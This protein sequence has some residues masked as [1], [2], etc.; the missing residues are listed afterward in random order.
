MKQKKRNRYTVQ[1]SVERFT[2]RWQRFDYSLTSQ[3]V[4]R[5]HCNN[6]LNRYTVHQI[7]ITLHRMLA[8]L[9]PLSDKSTY[10]K[11]SLNDIQSVNN[12]LTPIDQFSDKFDIF[13]KCYN[14]L[15]KHYNNLLKRCNDLLNRYTISRMW[16]INKVMIHLVDCW[17]DIIIW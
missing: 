9:W 1:Q 16:M 4:L 13:W 12:V 17:W 15:W 8:T 10:V 7:V 14:G 5:N 2:R 3:Y 11:E 6:Y